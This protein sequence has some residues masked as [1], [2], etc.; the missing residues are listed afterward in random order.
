MSDKED[1]MQ[2]PCYNCK[3]KKECGS[4]RE[5]PPCQGRETR[6]RKRNGDNNVMWKMQMA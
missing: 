3:Y 2:N 6:G 4:L 5:G 1:D